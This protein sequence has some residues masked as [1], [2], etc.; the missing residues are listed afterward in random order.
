[1][2]DYS[3]QLANAI[4]AMTKRATEST[5][6]FSAPVKRA[7]TISEILDIGYDGVEPVQ[8]SDGDDILRALTAE[9]RAQ[10]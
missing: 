1:M 8:M 2:P 10:D 7:L 3:K 5:L 6:A 9:T 4:N